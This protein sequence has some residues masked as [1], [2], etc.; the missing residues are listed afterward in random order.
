MTNLEYLTIETIEIMEKEKYILKWNMEVSEG[1]QLAKIG[2][3]FYLVREVY[4]LL[5]EE[6]EV[7]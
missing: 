2:P 1:I 3:H 7:N 4:H 6:S 5:L